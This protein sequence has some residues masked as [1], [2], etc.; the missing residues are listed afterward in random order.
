MNG[1]LYDPVLHRF[2]QPDNYVQD[3]MN[4]QNYNRYGYVL[5]NPLRFTD[6][7]GEIVWLPIIIG[8]VIGAYSGGV[9]ANAGELNPFKWEYNLKTIGYILGGAIV[10]GITG[11]VSN[12]ISTSGVAFANTKAIIAGSAINSI[13]TYIYT[14]GETD[15][16][17]SIGFAS[18]NFT[19][20]E[21]NY[22]GKKGNS[23]MENL[24]FG[25]GAVA[26]IS[27]F[28]AG[29]K[30][31]DVQLNTDTSDAI[32]HSAITDVGE[33]DGL[34]S[35]ISVG[36]D[37]TGKRIFNP[38][39]LKNKA[40]TNW[41]NYVDKSGTWKTVVKGVN[42]KT[43]SNYSADL[44]NGAK[45]NLYF[46]SCVNHTARALTFSGVPVIGIH[47]FI[48]HAQVYLRSIG[49]RPTLILNQYNFS[50]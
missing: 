15:F 46:S 21:F 2:L 17:I 45:Y 14:G 29:S 26:V 18:F 5:N 3:P 28:L 31:G 12:S 47:P 4:S 16:S 1:R 41:Q 48:L 19:K 23:F 27:D 35:I 24:G 36:P 8:A 10:G 37:Q 32:S 25:L 38:F 11:G 49:L 34:K 9:L 33:T 22:L 42:L 43:M 20:G 7:S 6:P 50:N 44:A 13:G 39:D 30:P 40:D